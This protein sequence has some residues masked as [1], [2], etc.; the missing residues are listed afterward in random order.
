MVPLDRSVLKAKYHSAAAA[1]GLAGPIPEAMMKVKAEDII[2]VANSKG[3][4]RLRALVMATVLAAESDSQH[5]L[6]RAAIQ[7]PQLLGEIDEVANSGGKAGHAND[8]LAGD[9]DIMTPMRFARTLHE[10]IPGARLA[11]IRG[12]GHALVLTHAEEFNRVV[13]PFLKES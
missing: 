12:G 1:V 6:R 3:N 13:L 2:Y 10:Q 11:V 5:P 4:W 8:Q 7:N 9:D